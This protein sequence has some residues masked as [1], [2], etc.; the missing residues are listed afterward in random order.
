MS[1]KN[2]KRKERNRSKCPD[3]YERQVKTIH[4]GYEKYLH[5]SPCPI[6]I[7]EASNF[8]NDIKVH[9]AKRLRNL[10]DLIN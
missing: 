1:N 7:K 8:R 4:G 9:I 5:V 6:L 3:S 10:W 2:V